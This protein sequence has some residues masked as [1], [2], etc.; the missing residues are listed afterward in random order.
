MRLTVLGAGPAYTDRPGATGASY[1]VS[2]DDTH[3]LLDLGQGSLPR[4]FSAIPPTDLAA[5]V[6]SHLHP[7]HFIDLVA[8]RH[9]LRWEFD[10]PRRVRVLGPA[11]LAERLDALHGE[12]GFAAQALDAEVLGTG[13]RD[14]GALRVKAALVQH[15]DESYGIRVA[16]AG[17]GPGLVYS[18]DCGRA[19][20]L[21]PLLQPGDAL[22][23]EVSYGPGP[24]EPGVPHL[25][26]PAVG[27]VAA[28]GAAGRVLLTHIQMG[29]D[30]DETVRS[31][32]ARYDGSVEFVWPG[33]V[34]E[35]A[36]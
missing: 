33:S 3:V 20:D 5:V 1:L 7:D 21:A 25:D 4:L 30:P 16:P 9:Y 31:V 14:I 26:G 13:E 15:T 19:T 32:R 17:G 6:I 35:L 22:L 11:G 18:G 24:V 34:V 2:L 23:S 27:S 29:Y 28:S 8:L 12:P 36:G 10:P